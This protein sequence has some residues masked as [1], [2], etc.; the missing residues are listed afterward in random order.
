MKNLLVGLVIA[1]LLVGGWWYFMSNSGQEVNMRHQDMAGM[2]TQDTTDD[3]GE[4]MVECPVMGTR[5]PAAQA[6][7]KTEYK[8][9]TYY[10][11][12]APCEVQFKANPEKFIK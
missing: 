2:E 9:K 6:Y 4:N 11:C 3:I 5:F 7:A 1:L 12:C 10:F 8:G